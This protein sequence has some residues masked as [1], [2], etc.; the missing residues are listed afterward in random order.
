MTPSG[1]TIYGRSY[2]D[3]QVD[4]DLASLATGKGK[5]DTP[6]VARFGGFACNAARAISGR[7]PPGSIRVVTTA[8]WLDWPRL[9]AALPDDVL[10]DAL[11]TRADAAAFPPISVILNPSGTC[12]ILRD[13]MDHDRADWQVKQVSGEALR[14]GLHMMGRLPSRFA[15]AV[16]ARCRATKSRFAWVGGDALPRKLEQACDLLCVNARE[17]GRLLGVEGRSPREMAEALAKRANPAD[18]VRVVTG[19]GKAPATAAYREGRRVRFVESKPRTIAKIRRLLA[20]GDVFAACFL[21]AA[22]FDSKGAPR[23]RL[24]VAGALAAAQ[25]AAEEFLVS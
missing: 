11:P 7:L 24:D 10:L 1:I 8:S 9:R 3:V 16:L 20:V 13:R 5:V 15:S 18:A 4:V 25:R 14:A 12:R 17:A 2:V 22:C 6:I 23:R 19:A 21:S